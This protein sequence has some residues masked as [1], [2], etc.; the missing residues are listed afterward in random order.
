MDAMLEDSQLALGRKKPRRQHRP[1]L[2]Q[3]QEEAERI[4]DELACEFKGLMAVPDQVL[5]H[6]HARRI[7]VVSPK[8]PTRKSLP[9]K[10]DRVFRGDNW[11]QKLTQ[12]NVIIPEL[13][14]QL[15]V[16]TSLIRK[17]MPLTNLSPR[18][19]KCALIGNLPPSMTL[20]NL[21][22]AAQYLDWQ[23][24]WAYLNLAPFI[25]AMHSHRHKSR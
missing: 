8:D 19:L 3:C 11:Q 24:Q 22:S 2:Q 23:K 20:H 7:A 21:L 16:S 4:S 14:K 10:Q 6:V 1:R 12:D 9:N 13:A 15:S 18:I 17:Y 5:K 25:K